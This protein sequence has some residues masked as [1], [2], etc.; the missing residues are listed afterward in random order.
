M[1]KGKDHK[2]RRDRI[3]LRRFKITTI[4][5]DGTI[6]KTDPLIVIATDLGRREEVDSFRKRWE[7]RRISL[8]TSLRGQFGIVEGMTAGKL[9]R[10]MNKM[11]PVNGIKQFVRFL[12]DLGIWVVLLTDNPSCVANFALK[13]G[14]QDIICSRSELS[15]TGIIGRM[16][17]LVNKATGLSDYCKQNGISLRECLHVGNGVN[18]IPVFRRVGAS[19]AINP[20]NRRVQRAA[21]FSVDT[22]TILDLIRFF[23]Y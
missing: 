4:D 12:I 13:L 10:Y 2:R 9:E 5:Q 3:N 8:A 16:H 22:D 20:E 23:V 14:F 18:D 15:R 17:P 21:D 19:I 6:Y 11:R 7:E 1:V